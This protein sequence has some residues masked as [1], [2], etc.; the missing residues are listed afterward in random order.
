M[1]F[2]AG[3]Y[4]IPDLAGATRRRRPR[5]GI[6]GASAAFVA[7]YIA[8]RFLE[9]FFEHRTLTPFAIYCLVVGGISIIHFA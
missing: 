3:V 1:I 4:K 5:P 9:R 2:A 7:A 6:V 8:V